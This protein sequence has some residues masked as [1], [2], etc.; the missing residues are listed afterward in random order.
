MEGPEFPGI[1]MPSLASYCTDKYLTGNK[2]QDPRS[3]S[4]RQRQ[5]AVLRT[6]AARKP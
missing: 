6:R 3:L 4:K 2:I 5:E 1:K